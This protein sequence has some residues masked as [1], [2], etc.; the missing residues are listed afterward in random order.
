M[1]Q[2]KK[3][4]KAFRQALLKTDFVQASQISPQTHAEKENV[5]ERNIAEKTG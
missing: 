5:T 2:G 1:V 3:A 4:N